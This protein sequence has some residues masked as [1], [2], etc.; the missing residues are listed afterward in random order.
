MPLP[1]TKYDT[2][3]EISENVYSSFLNFES[4]YFI[5]S[6]FVS[7]SCILYKRL[8]HISIRW[9][10]LNISGIYI[11]TLS[12]EWGPWSCTDL[13]FLSH[14]GPLSWDRSPSPGI[15]SPRENPSFWLKLRM[16]A[17]WLGFKFNWPIPYTRTLNA[18]VWHILIPLS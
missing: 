15:N 9:E 11:P 5:Y 13:R 8:R 2:E 18:K 16:D 3:D 4:F 17:S 12:M 6:P 10:F 14:V 7:L 1:W